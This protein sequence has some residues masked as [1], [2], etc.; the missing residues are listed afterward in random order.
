MESSRQ[1]IVS[2]RE[3][4]IPDP[5]QYPL[6]GASA[7]IPSEDD[8][9]HRCGTLA[10]Y[11]L[12]D[13]KVMALTSH[14]VALGSKRIAPFPTENE[15]ATNVSYTL[16]Q[17]AECDLKYQI[18]LL[19]AK[20]KQILAIREARQ[21]PGLDATDLSTVEAALNKL[22]LWTPEKCVLGNVWKTSG[23]R[24]RDADTPNRCC[25]DWALIELENA[26]RFT[27]RANLVNE[28]EFPGQ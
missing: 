17:P 7:S 16:L 3:P 4:A 27:E 20:R 24:V 19:K 2:F 6:V 15:E 13:G 21:D 23:T 10:G 8:N 9:L 12:V 28:V 18:H 14:H 26:E 1:R 5:K 25:F 11:V 22:N